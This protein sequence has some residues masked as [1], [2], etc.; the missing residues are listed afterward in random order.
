MSGTSLDGID[1]ALCSFSGSNQYYDWGILETGYYAYEAEMKE[2]LSTAHLLETSEF[3]RFHKEFGQ[4]LGKKINLFLRDKQRP[5]FIASHGHTVFHDPSRKFTFQLGDGA[6]IRAVTG[7]STVSDFRNLD[8]AL[9]GQGAP[10]VPPGDKFLFGG[11]DYCVNL[12]GFANISHDRAGERIAYDICP[13]NFVL[14]KYSEVL[15][16]PYDKDGK[17]GKGGRIREELL[18]ALD[19]IGYY[20]L[21][22]PKSL[23]RE[24]VVKDYFPLIDGFKIS[25][26]DKLRTF[27]EHIAGRISSAFDSDSR[28][29]VLFTGGGSYNQF[30]ISEIRKRT[31]QEIVLPDKEIID[32]KEAIIF[33]FLA[34]LRI[35]EEF[36]TFLSVTGAE[37]NSIG[38]SIFV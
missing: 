6:F 36:N 24:N 29:K 13:V 9:G 21:S 8:T 22:P 2:S 1:F 3:L 7:I 27:Y 28:G 38:G 17:F 12:G 37:S 34:Y 23:S 4:Y 16:A 19:G 14:N 32:Y 11:Y 5:A 10:L 31:Q 33:A 15:G 26:H 25:E 20:S 18:D 35:N 30:L